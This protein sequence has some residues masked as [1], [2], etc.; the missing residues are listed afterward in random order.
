MSEKYKKEHLPK[1]TFT[2]DVL[3][4]SDV[5]KLKPILETHIKDDETG[6]LVQTEI[7]EIQGYMNGE[8]DK[9]GRT[10][11]YF[12]AKDNKGNILGCVGITEPEPIMLSHF[13]T[14]PDESMEIV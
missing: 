12:V 2:V 11:T 7:D 3:T 6:E 14:T 8:K 5:D 10:R 1:E 9:F 13:S 4:D